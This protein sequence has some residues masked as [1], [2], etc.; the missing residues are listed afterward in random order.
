VLFVAGCAG[1]KDAEKPANTAAKE[2]PLVAQ[3]RSPEAD[4]A[5]RGFADAAGK[6]AQRPD[7]SKVNCIATA[8]HVFG[9]NARPPGVAGTRS[10]FGKVVDGVAVGVKLT[11]PNPD[12][13]TPGG[14]KPNGAI[15]DGAT[16]EG[17]PSEGRQ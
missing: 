15:P 1:G 16:P 9:C 11:D 14:A 5:R 2:S 4:E 6:I 17:A 13:A 7:D 12:G 3:N 10:I 8:I